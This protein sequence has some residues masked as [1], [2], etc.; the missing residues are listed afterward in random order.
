MIKRRGKPALTLAGPTRGENQHF[1]LVAVLN[2]VTNCGQ[3]SDCLHPNAF[4]LVQCSQPFRVLE[5][6]TSKIEQQIPYFE[7]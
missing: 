6:L 7:D 1:T 4:G 3:F 2:D 5:A